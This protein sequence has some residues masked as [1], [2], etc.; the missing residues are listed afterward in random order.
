MDDM[1][2]VLYKM[3]LLVSAA[4]LASC[5]RGEVPSQDF[6]YLADEFADLRIMRFRIPGWDDLT[7]RQKE[8]AYHLAEAAK[9][10]RDITWDQ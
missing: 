7:L 3:M 10:G 4:A 8:Y 9:Y 2:K 6:K 5:G 1:M